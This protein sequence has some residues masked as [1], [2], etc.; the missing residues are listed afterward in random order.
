MSR[1]G[2]RVELCCGYL[3]H[4]R[5]WRD[6]SLIVELFT[7]EHGRLTAFARGAR[8][9][10]GAR[11]RYCG[12]QPFR[13]LLLSWTGR[14]EAPTLTA[15]ENDGPAPPQLAPE[16][17]L[18]AWYLNELLLKLTV[19]HDPHP[20]LYL[21]YQAT[22]EQLRAGVPLDTALRQFEL[23]LLELLGF[24]VELDRDCADGSA[25]LE[26]AYY[27]FSAGEGVRRQRPEQREGADESPVL[28]GQVLLQLAE[29]RLPEDTR[30]LRAVRALLRAAL[31][32]CL[33]G[34]ELKTRVV[35]RA[36]ARIRGASA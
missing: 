20:E 9:T 11:T 30:Q 17:L 21:Q 16:A 10:R 31:D 26:D 34:R 7:A 25:V 19:A 1:V 15:A 5:P 14:G 33:E 3:L 2:A 27:H 13:P 12:L 29:G 35:A 36:V 23:R 32:H 22:L 24:G 6:T 4:Q 8:G 28:A 18:S